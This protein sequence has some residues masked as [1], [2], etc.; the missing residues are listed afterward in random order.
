MKAS[1]HPSSP[2][3]RRF[4]ELRAQLDRIAVCLGCGE[5]FEP[6]N[7]PGK[8]ACPRCGSYLRWTDQLIHAAVTYGVDV[9]RAVVEKK[10]PDPALFEQLRNLFRKQQRRDRRKDK[11][12]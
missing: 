12:E 1:S 9:A 5:H 8:A 10:E 7:T 4:A 11:D 6:E 3:K 2:L